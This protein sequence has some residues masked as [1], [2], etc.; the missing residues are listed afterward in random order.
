MQVIKLFRQ[1]IILLDQGSS[2]AAGSPAGR[3]KGTTVR[4]AVIVEAVRTPIGRR[5]GALSDVHP[6]DLAADVLSA[7]IARTGIEPTAI[8]DVIFG[9]VTQIGDQSTNV[10]RLAVLAA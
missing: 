10:A 2:L 9:C 6:V 7:L 3:E 4:D 5:N 8:E 1:I